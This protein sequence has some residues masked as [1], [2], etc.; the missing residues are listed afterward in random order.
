MSFSRERIQQACPR[1][2]PDGMYL[3]LVGL[4]CPCCPSLALAA[5]GVT[6]AN[7]S[8]PSD[9]INTKFTF[10]I[11]FCFN[12]APTVWSRRNSSIP[13]RHP[14]F[15]GNDCGL[16]SCQNGAFHTDILAASGKTQIL[17]FYH[18]NSVY[19]HLKSSFLKKKCD[20]RRSTMEL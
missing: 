14:L 15:I 10:L 16:I 5:F 3:R 4:K 1:C 7:V 13:L 9:L 12:D 6:I 19:F 8:K 17:N 18:S 20:L 11:S 2:L